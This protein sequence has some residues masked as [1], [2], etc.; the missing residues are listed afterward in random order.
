MEVLYIIHNTSMV[1][2][3]NYESILNHI[4]NGTELTSKRLEEPKFELTSNSH[5]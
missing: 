2:P 1:P 5:L 3:N 4:K